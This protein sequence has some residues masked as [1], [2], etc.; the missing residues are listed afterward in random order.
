MSDYVNS[1]KFK[2][3]SSSVKGS[4]KNPFVPFFI[5]VVLALAALMVQYWVM[6]VNTEMQRQIQEQQQQQ[7]QQEQQQNT[8][9]AP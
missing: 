8:D 9:V 3:S 1:S 6:D 7:Q 2:N 5:I 4:K